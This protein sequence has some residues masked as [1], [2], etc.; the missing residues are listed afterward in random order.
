MLL[1][2][3]KVEYGFYAGPEEY[4]VYMAI[5][6]FDRIQDPETPLKIYKLTQEDS[7][8]FTNFPTTIILNQT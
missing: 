2:Y 5:I 7:L 8:L 1:T 4:L 6:N 3:K